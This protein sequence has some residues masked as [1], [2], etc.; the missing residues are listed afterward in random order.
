[1]GSEAGQPRCKSCSIQPWTNVGFILVKLIWQQQPGKMIA[2]W[3]YTPTFYYQTQMINQFSAFFSDYAR[4][5]FCGH[6]PLLG[7]ANGITAGPM[8]RTTWLSC[9]HKYTRAW[10]KRVGI[11]EGGGVGWSILCHWR[12]KSST[13]ERQ[14]KFQ[15]KG[16]PALDQ[17]MKWRNMKVNWHQG[18]NLLMTSQLHHNGLTQRAQ[19]IAFL[20]R[21][22][23][24][25]CCP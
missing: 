14:F 10:K 9:I 21:I 24:L 11:L 23:D 15:L 4:S 12:E 22:C 20:P 7:C 18:S 6:L 8:L 5:F 25:V 2:S 13:A 3:K 19:W 1:M 17:K 16:L